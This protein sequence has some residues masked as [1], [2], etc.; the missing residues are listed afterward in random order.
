[1]LY[2]KIRQSAKL[3]SV[4]GVWLVTDMDILN[5]H[6]QIHTRTHMHMA[7]ERTLTLRMRYALKQ[8]TRRTKNKQRGRE[9]KTPKSTSENPF[10]LPICFCHC[11]C[12]YATPITLPVRDTTTTRTDSERI[13]SCHT[14]ARVFGCW[15]DLQQRS[16]TRYGT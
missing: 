4:L 5:C 14:R 8:K 9:E 3:K 12:L 11:C 13:S 16:H 15:M 10:D 1:M 2:K 6:L 7:Q